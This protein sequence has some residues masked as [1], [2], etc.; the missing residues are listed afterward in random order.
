MKMASSGVN[1]SDM[2]IILYSGVKT[3]RAVRSFVYSPYRNI[4]LY[5]YTR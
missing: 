1:S 5:K 3:L 4:G 2:V